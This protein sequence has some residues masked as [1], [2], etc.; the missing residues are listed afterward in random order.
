[1]AGD[2]NVWGRAVA[3]VLRRLREERSMTQKAV[4]EQMG[5]DRNYISELETGERMPRIDT[6]ANAAGALGISLTE[7]IG[8]IEKENSRLTRRRHPHIAPM[9]ASAGKNRQP[10]GG[11]GVS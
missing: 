4:G 3:I 5:V 7:F 2:L 8:F 9:R 10:S 11:G 1:M 6:L